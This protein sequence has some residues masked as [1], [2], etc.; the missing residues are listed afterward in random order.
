M[1]RKI[2]TTN[3]LNV[4]DTDA[5]A[6]E[7]LEEILLDINTVKIRLLGRL[8]PH[9]HGVSAFMEV[10]EIFSDATPNFN[11]DDFSGY[12]W[13]TPIEALAKIAGGDPAKDD[14]QKLLEI[15]YLKGFRKRQPIVTRNAFPGTS[16]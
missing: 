9:E 5:L 2:R 3:Q 15:F 7:T 11:K 12:Y 4:N 13:L 10:Y 1:K 16:D 8:T 6:R 14:L